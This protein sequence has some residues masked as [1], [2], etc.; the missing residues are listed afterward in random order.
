VKFI[1]GKSTTGNRKAWSPIAARKTEGAG[2]PSFSAL[3]RRMKSAGREIHRGTLTQ[4]NRFS[5][6]A[7][8][9]L[10]MACGNLLGIVSLPQG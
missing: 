2:W 5:T 9:N 4:E 1:C 8:L 6:L 7:L 10:A 3:A